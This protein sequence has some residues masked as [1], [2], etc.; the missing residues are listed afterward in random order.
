MSGFT[1]P[2]LL[3]RLGRLAL[4]LVVATAVVAHGRT[5]ARAAGGTYFVGGYV[6]I[7]G[8]RDYHGY[9]PS[10]YRA[11]TP[12]PLVVALHGCTENDL[13]FDL[14]SGWTPRPSSRDSSSSSPTRTTS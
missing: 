12:M 4:V 10:S 9:V 3:R 6:S 5:P 7:Y 1:A 14:L 2:P 8:A 13:G 11:G